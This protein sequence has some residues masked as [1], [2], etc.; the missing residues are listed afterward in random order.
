MLTDLNN[1]V[2]LPSGVSLFEAT[3]INDL[4]EIVAYGNNGH[5]YF[6]T[7]GNLSTPVNS[8]FAPLNPF[9]FYAARPQAPPTLNMASTL[10]LPA[11]T[12]LAA[13]GESAVVLAYQSKSP[14]PVTF[15]LLANSTG[16]PAGSLG[17]FDP[18]Y[19]ASPSPQ[20]AMRRATR[21]QVQPPGRMPVAT[22]CFWRYWRANAMPRLPLV[23]LSVTAAQQGQVITSQASI[24]V[25]SPPPGAHP[26][27]LVECEG[28]WVLPRLKR[29]LRLDLGRLSAQRDI[30]G[31]L[32]GSE[33]PIL[34]RS[35]DTEQTAVGHDGCAR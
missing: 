12:S 20:A 23:N 7:P 33:F 31:R 32:P 22:T 4:G 29:L 8:S 24:A 9:A 13:D 19:L 26:R 30:P 5:A 2:T 17:Q 21:S 6:L 3:G 1:L 16:Q 25:E 11:A 28:V 34:Q 10:G 35:K 27:H 18:N 15:T 14:Q